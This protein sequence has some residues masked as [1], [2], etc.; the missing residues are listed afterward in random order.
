MSAQFLISTGLQPGVPAREEPGRFNG[1]APVASLTHQIRPA[2]PGV[3]TIAA[4]AMECGD[5]S[6]HSIVLRCL[7]ASPSLC[8]PVLQQRIP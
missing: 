1:L 4:R 2:W 7:D 5:E 3:R 8:S 6:P